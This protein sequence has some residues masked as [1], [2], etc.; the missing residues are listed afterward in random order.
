M[1]RKVFVIATILSIVW[2][3]AALWVAADDELPADDFMQGSAAYFT[4][5]PAPSPSTDEAPRAAT[6][7]ATRSSARSSYARLARAPNMFGDS[8][9]NM[10]QLSVSAQNTNFL[11][12]LPLGG[13]R[14]LKVAEN[15]KALP[16]D[17]VYFVYNGF[18]NAAT[19]AQ[20]ANPAALVPRDGNLNRYTFGIEKT[21]LD[22]QWSVDVR[23]PVTDNFGFSN[24]AFAFDSG[25]IGNL[26]L[27]LKHWCYSSDSL[28]VAGG[29]GLGLP[30]GSDLNG[31]INQTN[32]TL[33]NDAVHLVPYIGFLMLPTDA[34]FIQGFVDADIA[35]SGNAV[36]FGP[37]RSQAGTLTEQNLLHV[38][39]SAAHWV[40]R[41]EVATYVTGVAAI[42]ELHYTSAMQ[43]ADG[44]AFTVAGGA[45]P[46][47]VGTFQNLANR[48]DILHLTA[49]LHF[50]IGDVSNL[51]VGCVVPVRNAPDRQFDS[52]IQVSFNRSF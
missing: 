12:D 28:S 31:Q 2:S 10:G 18:Q 35:A 30:T 46:A 29:L 38:D 21:F 47:G 22:G 6:T 5:Q 3:G 1:I 24:P 7:R 4:S 45:G 51:R 14:N 32:F 40:Y 27:F 52:E 34:C 39:L 11:T 49:G 20:G 8:I 16:M 25:D 48:T 43:D 17:R 44:F 42:T 15:N 36:D 19:I 37:L 9:G 50:Q 13:G 33:R 23:M 26:A 41:N